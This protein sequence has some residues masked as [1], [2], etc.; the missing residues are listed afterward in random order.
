[1]GTEWVGDDICIHIA[2]N[3]E[4]GGNF[5]FAGINLPK[6]ALFSSS[7]SILFTAIPI[8]IRRLFQQP[9]PAAQPLILRRVEPTRC[10]ADENAVS[11]SAAAPC[12]CWKTP[13]PPSCHTACVLHG[14]LASRRD[15]VGLVDLPFF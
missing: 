8:C 11:R 1:M 3:L 14:L 13:F 15:Q 9:F 10:H 6:R 7:Y 2:L 4:S 5:L 12:C